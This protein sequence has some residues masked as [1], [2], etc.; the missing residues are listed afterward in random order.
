MSAEKIFI[1]CEHF[2]CDLGVGT[3]LLF[4]SLDMRCMKTVYKKKSQLSLGQQA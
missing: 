3:Y 4:F 1:F 2:S